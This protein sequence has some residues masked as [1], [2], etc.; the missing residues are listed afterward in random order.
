MF[1]KGLS[2]LKGSAKAGVGL[3]PEKLLLHFNVALCFKRFDVTCKISIGSIKGFL[4]GAEVNPIVYHQ[5]R[6]DAEPNAVLEV[7]VQVND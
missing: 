3:F 2:S 4:H 7:L 1:V 6:H 5:H